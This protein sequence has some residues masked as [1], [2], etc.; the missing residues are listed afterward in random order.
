MQKGSGPSPRSRTY[1]CESTPCPNHPGPK[2]SQSLGICLCSQTQPLL[3]FAKMT[4]GTLATSGAGSPETPAL[5]SLHEQTL[6]GCQAETSWKYLGLWR[7][8]RQKLGGIRL[9]LARPSL[10][11]PP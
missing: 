10:K 3:M 1:L 8:W 5:A 6:E 4:P 2:H 7:M 11:T 9:S